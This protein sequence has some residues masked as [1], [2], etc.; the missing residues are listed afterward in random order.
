MADTETPSLIHHPQATELTVLREEAPQ[1]TLVELTG[2][3]ALTELLAP[4]AKGGKVDTAIPSRDLLFMTLSLPSTDPQELQGMAELEAE[5]ISPFPPERTC[6]GWE[7]LEQSE[8]QS[9]IL[10]ALCARKHVETLP[11]NLQTYGMIPGRVDAEILAGIENLKRAGQLTATQDQLLLYLQGNDGT[12][13]AWQQGIP[14]L[15]RSLM[16]A[17]SYSPETL[18]EEVE[19]AQVALESGGSESTD[20]P[21]HVWFDGEAPENW[22]GTFHPLDQ[23]PPLSQG[24]WARGQ[25]ANNLNLAPADWKRVEDQKKKRKKQIRRAATLVAIWTLFILSFSIWAGMRQAAVKK[26]EQENRTRATAVTNVQELIQRTRSLSQFTDRST[27]A[28]ETMRLLAEAAP[29]SGSILIEDYRYQ[30]SEGFTFSGSIKG[31]VQPFYVFYEQ[32]TAHPLLQVP[33]LDLKESKTGFTFRVEVLWEWIELD[34]T[35]EQP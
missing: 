13:V 9:R 5:E 28:L 3:E 20:L 1:T 34:E 19:L 25:N 2:P 26:L 22:P 32:L 15:I 11:E 7:I 14:V 6:L 17:R 12:L 24:L 29:G 33:V 30:K 21:L 18:R 10:L 31:D 8:K 35:E 4:F 23:L 27:S 16:D